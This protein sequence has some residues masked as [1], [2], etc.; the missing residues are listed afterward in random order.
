M[1]N[2][3]PQELENFWKKG[4]TLYASLYQFTAPEILQE[5]NDLELKLKNHTHNR[6]DIKNSILP[7]LSAGLADLSN[8]VFLQSQIETIRDKLKWDLLNIILS[9]K[10]IGIGYETPV[11]SSD[12]PQIIPLHIWPQKIKEINWDDSSILKNG[13]QFLNIRIIKKLP[14][15]KSTTD[16]GIILPK[17]EKKK[18]GRPSRKKEIIA[19]YEDLKKAGLIDYSIPLKSHTE[20]IQKNIQK[21]FPEIKEIKGMKHEVIRRYIGD[22]FQ[23]DRNNKTSSKL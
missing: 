21:L 2:I 14:A 6:G 5:Y 13:V 10:L 22:R 11:K 18:V 19:A 12:K 7:T 4:K 1:E 9:E 16:K 3:P 23:E 20:L 17:A 15:K 8:L